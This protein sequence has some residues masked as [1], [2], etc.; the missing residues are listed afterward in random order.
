[1]QEAEL[2]RMAGD[3]YAKREQCR[4]AAWIKPKMAHKKMVQRLLQVRAHLIL[5]FRAEEKIEMLR[6]DKGKLQV[7]PK[8]SPTGLHGWI[9]VCEKNLPYE[10]TVSFLLTADKP[11]FPQPIKLQEQHREMFPLNQPIDEQSGRRV[12]AWAAGGKAVTSSPTAPTAP[13]STLPL[14]D[15]EHHVDAMSDCESLEALKGAFESAKRAA[16]KD[17][18]ALDR[19][20]AVKD[21]NK[22]RIEAAVETI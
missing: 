2:D 4:M 20:T 17:R 12:A 22:R 7:V 6:D 16:G 3:N 18:A 15:I 8:A 13:P 21:T 10:L 19:F 14:S 5:C 11:G 9:P 1:M